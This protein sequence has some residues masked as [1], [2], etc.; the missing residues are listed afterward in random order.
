MYHLAWCRG[1][2][3]LLLSNISYNLDI[4]HGLSGSMGSVV[5]L[6]NN[7][8]NIITNMAWVRVGLVIYK[9]GCTGLAATS[10]KVYQLL[11]HGRWFSPGTPTSSTTKTGCHDTAEILLKVACH[12]YMLSV[13][14][15]FFLWSHWLQVILYQNQQT[16]WYWKLSVSVMSSILWR[17]W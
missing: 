5:G 11:V 15:T 9:K 2:K 10:D 3:S 12:K 4:M 16:N 14:L 17:H 6:P 13:I 8:Y 1:D 7:S